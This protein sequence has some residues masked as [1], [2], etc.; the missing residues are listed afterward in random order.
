MTIKEKGLLTHNIN[1]MRFGRKFNW[2]SSG[3]RSSSELKI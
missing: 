2:T 1:N 3:G